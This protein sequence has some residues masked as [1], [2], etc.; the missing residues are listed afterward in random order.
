[1]ELVMKRLLFLWLMVAGLYS[2]KQA[3][4]YE[5]LKNV[6]GGEWKAGEKL[7]FSLLVQD[8]TV[9][10]N[11][12]ASIRHTNLYPYRNIWIR[13]GLQMPGTDSIT[14]QDF[15]LPLADNEKWLGSGLNDVYDRRVRL[16]GTPQR[17]NRLGTVVFTLQHI[18]RDDPLPGILQAG[19]R[20]EPDR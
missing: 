3:D 9:G 10:Y 2:C 15:E 8:T 6:P 19:I 18:M 4:L 11:L 12:S 16:F 17:F 14:Y 13:M 20:I 7:Y 1:M 5:R